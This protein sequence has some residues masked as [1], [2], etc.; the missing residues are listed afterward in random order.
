MI[1][2]KGSEQILIERIENKILLIRGQKVI[3]D[4]DLAELYGVETRRLN[5]QVKRNIKRFPDD[6]MF[7]LNDNEFKNWKSQFAISN[8][9]KMGLRHKPYVFTEHG[10]LMCSNL[11]KSD[12][13]IEVSILIVRAFIKLREML[14]LNKAFEAKFKQIEEKLSHHDKAII[15]IVKEIKKLS[16]TKS[17][18]PKIGF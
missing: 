17:N 14:S 1:I 15:A 6:F 9:D 16:Y 13:A 4:R 8:S 18:N 11:L 2:Y 12:R 3:L 7:Q 5:E 10:A